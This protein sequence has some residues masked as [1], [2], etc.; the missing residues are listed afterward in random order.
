MYADGTPV[1]EQQVTAR[2]GAVN[3]PLI[4]GVAQHLSGL[5]A[6]NLG[7]RCRSEKPGLIGRSNMAHVAAQDRADAMLVGRE[8]VRALVAGSTDRMVALRGLGD[9]SDGGTQLVP[10]IEAAGPARK[11]PTDWLA[12]KGQAVTKEYAEYVGPLTG[13]LSH[14]QVLH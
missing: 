4:G 6:A 11:L 5:V 3:R 13:E 1:F 14:Y 12:P 2:P 8:G 7:I 10:L 9:S